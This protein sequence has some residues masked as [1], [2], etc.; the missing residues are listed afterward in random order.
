[1]TGRGRPAGRP[2]RSFEKFALSH[3]GLLLAA[4]HLVAASAGSRRVSFPKRCNSMWSAAAVLS[5]R[6]CVRAAQPASMLSRALPP[7]RRSAPAPPNSWS[8]PPPLD[9]RSRPVLPNSTSRV[10][11][12][13]TRSHRCRR[14]GC[15]DRRRRECGR[16]RSGRRSCRCPRSPEVV[17]P[18]EAVDAVIA[19]PAVD[20]V[21]ASRAGDQIPR[22]AAPERPARR[23]CG[24]RN[25]VGAASRLRCR[26]PAAGL[27][28]RRRRPDRA[29][30]RVAE[31]VE[32]VVTVGAPR[33]AARRLRP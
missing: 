3:P 33:S 23:R 17:V 11:P 16:C 10:E 5:P 9:K 2:W 14:G 30:S 26:G 8:L 7:V 31:Q 6:R 32:A 13:V 21:P 15:R 19:G 25:R 24:G 20:H 18:A 27:P 12:P 4:R 28:G 22:G 1:M 29:R